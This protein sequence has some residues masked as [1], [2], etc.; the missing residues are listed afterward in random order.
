MSDVQDKEVIFASVLLF[1]YYF[2]AFLVSSVSLA[3]VRILVG[4]G[5]VPLSALGGR[6]LRVLLGRLDLFWKANAATIHRP[7]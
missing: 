1:I 6:R 7:L 5:V 4:C 3:S 2:G